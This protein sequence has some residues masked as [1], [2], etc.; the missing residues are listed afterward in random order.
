[1]NTTTL[2]VVADLTG[3][4]YYQGKIP[5]D[6]EFGYNYFKELVSGVYATLIND[7]FNLNKVKNKSDSG[8]SYVEVSADWLIKEDVVVEKEK[9]DYVIRTK[10]NIQTF[11]YDAMSSGV[12]FIDLADRK[13]TECLKLKRC[14]LKESNKTHLLPPSSVVFFFL[15]KENTIKLKG[16]VNAGE[17]FTVY[18]IPSLDTQDDN[19]LISED[20]KMAIVSTAL[21]VMFGSKN[22]EIKDATND[23]NSNVSPQTELNKDTLTK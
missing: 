19:A 8:S 5:D 10:S 7:E 20:K 9:G 11:R 18:Y 15:E 12:Q 17:K 21:S 3:D 1:M 13:D 2:K 22:G 16:K 6:A 14:T 23:S 4:L